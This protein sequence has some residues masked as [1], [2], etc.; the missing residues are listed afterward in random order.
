MSMLCRLERPARGVP[1]HWKKVK[2]GDL[3]QSL[4]AGVSVN[5]NDLP[6]RENQFGI[7]KT[8]CVTTGIFLPNENKQIDA[9]E[10]I[11]ARVNPKKDRVIL[12]RMN[13]PALVGASAY[14]PEDYKNLFLPDRL[15]QL[16]PFENCVCMRWLAYVL[17]SKDHRRS[18]ADVATGTSNSMKNISKSAVLGLGILIPP[19]LEQQRIAKLFSIWDV[20]IEKTEQL[21]AAKSQRLSFLREHH[22]TMSKKSS[23]V[24]LK[25][26]T[27]ESTAR[28]GKRLGRNAIMA[29]TKQIGMRPMREETIAA[30]IERYKVVRPKAFAYNPMRLN[31]GSIAMSSFDNDVLVSPDYVVFECDEAKLLPGYLNHLR[32]TQLWASHFEA[33]GSG[34]V[35]IRIYYDDLGAFAFPLP[36][37]IEQARVLTVLDAGVT[38]IETLE[39]YLAALKK[40]KRGLMQKLLTGQWRM[41]LPSYE[42]T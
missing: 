2:L 27:H 5:A 24:K 15:W 8:S 40:Q 36:P 42:E 37:V 23:R 20:A 19:L 35:R 39:R 3:I 12:S 41:K 4:D 6:A 18:L 16:E 9:H 10:I 28:N 1:K 11:S 22:L 17:A 14:V 7:L 26:A 31:I 25:A 38:E 21:I 13:T 30:A 32:R 29:V 33:A 34:G